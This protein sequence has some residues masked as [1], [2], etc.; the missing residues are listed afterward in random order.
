M[1]NPLAPRPTL[2]RQLDDASRAPR[3]LIVEDDLRYA[4]AL[5]QAL[6][7]NDP[8]FPYARLEVDVTADPAIA[9][10]HA[11]SDDID[12]YIIDLK[13]RDEEFPERDDPEIGKKLLKD[14]RATANA[15]I[16]VHSTEPALIDAA[17]TML[18]GADDFIE[19]M[20]RDGDY[21]SK[22][23]LHQI[24][25]AK[26]LAVWRRVQLVRPSTSDI[27]AHSDRVF[28]IGDLRFVVGHQELTNKIG[29]KIKISPTEHAFLR[30]LCT[31]EDHEIDRPTFNVS[32]L[33]R[34]ESE[35]DKRMDNFVYRMRLKLGPSVQLISRRDGVY[36]LINVSELQQ[37]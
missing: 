23:A 1:S 16:I 35:K 13:F 17:Q 24:I 37:R 6:R 8:A 33:G 10:R 27:F 30:Y 21:N 3:I 22:R 7:A 4:V 11:K 20:S 31:V 12:I 5:M 14:I 25:K 19:K 26:V 32:I 34:N 15:G 18:M 36:K 29:E 9:L 28:V 2:D